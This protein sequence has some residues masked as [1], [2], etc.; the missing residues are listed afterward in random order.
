LQTRVVKN[1]FRFQNR[2]KRIELTPAQPQI[3]FVRANNHQ[4]PP[5]QNVTRTRLILESAITSSLKI[6]T[7]ALPNRSAPLFLENP[8]TDTIAPTPA[9]DAGAQTAALIAALD[10]SPNDRETLIRAAL[11]AAHDQGTDRSQQAVRYGEGRFQVEEELGDPGYFNLIDTENADA[12]VDL[13]NFN[14][15]IKLAAYYNQT[16]GPDAAPS[17]D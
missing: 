9:F 16:G 15:M 11:Q 17:S 8:M 7:E 3:E 10:A 2:A 4:R 1:A 6:Q 14:D 12:N 13:G 5:N